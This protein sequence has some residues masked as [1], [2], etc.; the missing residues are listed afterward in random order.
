[1]LTHEDYEDRGKNYVFGTAP[2]S[3]HGTRFSL[4]GHNSSPSTEPSNGMHSREGP[5]NSL[6]LWKAESD[7]RIPCPPKE[8]GGCGGSVLDLKCSFPEKMLSELEERAEKI[9]RSEVF[10][11]AEAKRCYQ[12]PCYDHSGNIRTQD[13]RE[14]ANRKDSSDNH[15]YCPVATSI[16]EDDLMHF[17][18]HWT[19]GEPVIVSDVLQLTSGLSWEPLVMWRALREK[20]TNGNIEDEN[21]AVRAVDCLDWCEVRNYLPFYFIVSPRCVVIVDFPRGI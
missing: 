7:G 15:L 2:N 14:A 13:V 6:L 17:Q 8:L 10:A 9:M 1:M 12:C 3:K 19:K 20:K 18:M 4:R 16:K 21:F 11:K 5:N